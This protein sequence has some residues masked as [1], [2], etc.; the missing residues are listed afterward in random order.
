MLERELGMLD[1][2]LNPK[3][4]LTEMKKFGEWLKT[5]DFDIEQPKKDGVILLSMDQDHW[6]IAYMTYLLGK[7][8]G[9]TLDFLAPN[10]DIPDFDVYFLPS[11]AGQSV[12]YTQYYEQLKEKVANGATLY[13]S[14]ENG[15]FSQLKDFFGLSVTERD[16]VNVSGELMLD[17]LR[18]PYRSETKV[19][20]KTEGSEVVCTNAEG[21]TVMTVNS[22][23][24]GKVYYLAIPLEK[25]MLSENRAFDGNNYKV[26]ERVLSDVLAKKTVRKTHPKAGITENGNIVTVVNYSNKPI[27]PGITLANGK[28][29]GKLYRGS[30]EKI[31][32]CDALVF[33]IK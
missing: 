17:G 13:V 32:A 24:K 1:V 2:D 7:Q 31:D 18:I 8:A 29:I 26:Y 10:K 33:E 28:K 16:K 9:V 5:L 14:N 4:Y 27:D 15:F 11:A 21:D 3:P 12:L 6:G 22:Y 23:G 30:L 20:L 19:K 25:M